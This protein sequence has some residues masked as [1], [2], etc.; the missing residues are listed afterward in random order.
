[1]VNL[2]PIV[3][4]KEKIEKKRGRGGG[5]ENRI[6]HIRSRKKKQN[7]RR[8]SLEEVTTLYLKRIGRFREGLIGEAKKKKKEVDN[9]QPAASQN[10]KTPGEGSNVGR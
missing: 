10:K 4:E 8:A 9:E 7:K 2:G 1:L 5:G 6:T 3:K